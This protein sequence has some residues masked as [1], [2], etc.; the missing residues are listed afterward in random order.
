MADGVII[1]P[2]SSACYHKGGVQTQ[3]SIWRRWADQ[4]FIHDPGCYLLLGNWFYL[5]IVDFRQ[6]G[7]ALCTLR[8]LPLYYVVTGCTFEYIL[9]RLTTFPLKVVNTTSTLSLDL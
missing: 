9:V 4:Y 6:H 5:H 7:S 8:V 2:R 3:L 1:S